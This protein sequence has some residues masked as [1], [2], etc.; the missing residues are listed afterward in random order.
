LGGIIYFASY[1]IY[2]GLEFFNALNQTNIDATFASSL[3]SYYNIF[4]SAI[5]I[6]LSI[7]VFGDIILNKNREANRTGDK[8][9]DWYYKNEA[10]DRKMDERADKNNYRTM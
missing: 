8:K 3:T 9:T 4:F 1:F 6:I 7:F 2:F 5:G 10:Y